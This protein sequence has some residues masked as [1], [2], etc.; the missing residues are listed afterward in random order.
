[1]ADLFL[2]LFPKRLIVE[3]EAKN[4]TLPEA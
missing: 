2:D 4:T 1:M 3:G